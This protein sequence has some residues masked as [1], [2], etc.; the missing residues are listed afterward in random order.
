[1]TVP[2]P[3]RTVQPP[4]P[5]ASTTAALR[6]LDVH[7]QYAGAPEPVHALRG[8]S[9]TLETGSFTAVMGPSGSGKSTLLHCAAGLDIPTSGRV[10]VGERDI[11]VLSPDD[12]TRFRRDQ[13][14]FVFQSY[15]LIPH[16]SVAD[17]VRLPMILA[18]REPDP[19]WQDELLRAVGLDGMAQ[20]RPGELSGGQAQRVAIARALF[21]RPTVVFADE[22]T[23][24]LDARTGAAVL[25][26]LRETAQRLG[27]TVVMVTHDAQVAATAEQV[28]FLSD[29][30]LVDRLSDPTAQSVA[31]RMLGLER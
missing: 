28:L 25:A 17:N 5:G 26:L 6:L 16:L 31:D 3:T 2:T 1:M 24:A 8:V 21:S 27:Q 4:L 20:R 11:S 29:G 13:V 23:G 10:L 30:R 19:A 15:N 7:K 12:L 9:L 18:G 22:P 14:G